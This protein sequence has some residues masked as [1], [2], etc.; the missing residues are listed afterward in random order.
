M[1]LIIKLTNGRYKFDVTSE[2][3]TQHNEEEKKR[4]H[5]KANSFNVDVSLCV[6]MRERAWYVHMSECVF[7]CIVLRYVLFLWYEL[8]L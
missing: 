5:A 7:D 8:L 6:C 4:I 3:R 1:K 2:E